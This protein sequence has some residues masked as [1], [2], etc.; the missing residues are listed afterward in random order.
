M[1][2]FQVILCTLFIIAQHDYELSLISTSAAANDFKKDIEEKRRKFSHYSQRDVVVV[3]LDASPKEKLLKAG[4][5]VVVLEKLKAG[6][7][8]GNVSKI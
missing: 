5:V 3:V 2:Y 8:S 6:L 1:M 7:F 4:A